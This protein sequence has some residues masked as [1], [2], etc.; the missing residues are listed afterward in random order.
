MMK[1][2]KK[3]IV[4]SLLFLLFLSV[5]TKADYTLSG[6]YP[7]NGETELYPSYISL[8]VTA[9]HNSSNIVNLTF[10]SNL[11]GPWDYFYLGEDNITFSDISND[12]YCIS[13]P[14]FSEYGT[15]Y[16][17]YVNISDGVTSY[18]SPI[19][20]FSTIDADEEDTTPWS[21]LS[22]TGLIGSALVFSIF[23]I[24]A[25]MRTRRNRNV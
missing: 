19:F 9:T 23:G 15:T 10:Y 5:V 4:I 24:I 21:N 22:Q 7:Q 20:H 25:F 14:Y 11:S 16:Y 12:T 18:E 17:W 1:V 2:R 13:V 3:Y 8:C 6:F